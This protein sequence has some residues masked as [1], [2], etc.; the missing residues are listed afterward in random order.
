MSN[1]HYIEPELDSAL[2]KLIERANLVLQPASAIQSVTLIAI[3][4]VG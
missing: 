1:A 4:K 2:P 3:H